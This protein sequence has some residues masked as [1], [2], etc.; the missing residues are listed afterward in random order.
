MPA[1][2]AKGEAVKHEARGKI[3]RVNPRICIDSGF[4]DFFDCTLVVI[5]TNPLAV[6]WIKN[7]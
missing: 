2:K 4:A 1:D 7:T 3:R 6:T 5:A